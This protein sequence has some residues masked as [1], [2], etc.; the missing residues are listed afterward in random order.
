MPESSCK[1]L[2]KAGVFI[3]PASGYLVDHFK[4]HSERLGDALKDANQ[5]AWRT[6]EIALAG[7]SLRTLLDRQEEKAFRNQIRQALDANPLNEIGDADADFRRSCLDELREARRKGL[8]TAQ[9]PLEP[10]ALFRRASDFARFDR[11]ADLLKAEW[12]ALD[13]MAGSL[14]LDYPNLARLLTLRPAGGPS[15]LVVAVRYYFRRAIERDEILARAVTSDTIDRIDEAQARG[16]A[17]L[18]ENERRLEDLLGR[19]G[20]DIL[21]IKAEQHRQGSQLGDIYQGVLA[22]L[23]RQDRLDQRSLRL[24]DSLSFRNE[25]ERR[26]VKILVARF[27]A[28]P[29]DQRDRLPALLNALG[30]LE[31]VI[32]DAEEAGRDFQA[33]ALAVSDPRAKAEAHHNAYLAA[34]ERRRWP[35]A[36]DELKRAIALDGPRF[37]P[38]P[39]DK[40]E[41]E[42]LLGAGGFGVAFLSRHRYSGARVVIKALITDDLDRDVASIFTEANVL[43]DL[44]HPAIIGLRDCDYVD[45]ANRSRPYLI[46]DHFDGQSLEEYVQENGPLAVDDLE[47]LARTV[48]Q[49]LHAAHSLVILHRDVMPG[50]I[51]VRRDARGWQVKL[52]DFGLALRRSAIE[53]S[54]VR[55]GANGRSIVGSSIAGS[56][57]YAAPEQMGKLPGMAVGPYSDAYGF[58]KTCYY[59]LFQTPNPDYDEI[60]GLPNDWRLLLTQCVSER[61]ARRPADFAS[62]LGKWPGSKAGQNPPPDP[63]P[64]I[65]LPKKSLR[66]KNA[67]GFFKSGIARHEKGDLDGAIADYGQAIRL[68][69]KDAVAYYNRA[70]V[71]SE[72]GNLDAAITDYTEAIW[73][74]A[75]SAPSYVN[76]GL[77]LAEK[78]DVDG[79]MADYEKAIR[80]DPKAAL[81]YNNR[82]LSR[83]ARGD[84]DGAIADFA[85]AIRLDPSYTDAC[86]NRGFARDQQGDLDGAIADYSEAI[87]LNPRFANAFNNRGVARQAKGDLD[88]AIADSTEAIR[89]DPRDSVAY[90]NRGKARKVK[91]DLDGDLADYGEAIR[92]DSENAYAYFGRGNVCLAKGDPDGAIADYTEA[93]RLDPKSALA[94]HYRG[95]A[96]NAKEDLDGAIADYGEAIRLDPRSCGQYLGR[97]RRLG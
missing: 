88:G 85:E 60:G 68:D 22:M 50:N 63:Q 26:L 93:I 55:D 80:V 39:T 35:E 74:D 10:D 95:H 65:K 67:K 41:P 92:L 20:E 30:K 5:R 77:A 21:D 1:G 33:V 90:S 48:A 12:A 76:R 53:R 59:A 27:R 81:A 66:P 69:P 79:A 29:Q 52:I 82:G 47:P 56:I 57:D 91:R 28:L 16:F 18:D 43:E 42:R 2:N 32:G 94:Y 97:M 24:G 17:A 14:R 19:I 37:A 11:P 86:Y 61:V 36:L 34:L 4:D 13:Q 7:E 89:L 15:P 23:E 72:Q 78:G 87:R 62:I 54:I 38:F 9:G 45:A 8:L 75:K 58:G 51:L 84:L 46:L 83:A 6:L 73:L 71:L 96:R 44:K 25:D 49:A 3:M 40:Y 31:V 64:L 70:L